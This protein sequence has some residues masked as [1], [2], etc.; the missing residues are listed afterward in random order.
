[1]AMLFLIQVISKTFQDNISLTEQIYMHEKNKERNKTILQSTKNL[2]K[3][4]H[5]YS[6]HLAVIHEL[7]KTKSY[8]QLSQYVS[9]QRESLPQTFPMISTGHHIIDAILTDKYTIAQSENI[10]FMYSVVLPEH[11]PINDIEITGILG[12]LLDNSIEACI[13]IDRKKDTPPQINVFLKPQRSMFH[14]HVENSSPG[15]YL[16]KHNGQLN[17]TKTDDN[18]HGK[19]LANVREIAER[20]SGFCNITAGENSFITDVYIPLLTE[21]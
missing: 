7:I 4:K 20:H 9:L 1:M 14:I 10:S 18:D 2:Q 3:W 16:Y 11:L 19:G 5:D 13:N 8:H 17:S 12:N 21:R 6:N 15:N